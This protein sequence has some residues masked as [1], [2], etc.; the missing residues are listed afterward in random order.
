MVVRSLK[1]KLFVAVV[2]LGVLPFSLSV[3]VEAYLAHRRLIAETRERL[4]TAPLPVLRRMEILLFARWN[5]VHLLSHMPLFQDSEGVGY[6]AAILRRA[7]DL[8]QPDAWLALANERGRILASSDEKFMDTDASE[9]RWFREAGKISFRD[10]REAARS[11]YISE[12]YVPPSGDGRLVMCFNSPLYDTGGR[13]RGVVHSEIKLSA[14]IPFLSSLRMGK[15]GRALLV[16]GDG[17]ILLDDQN[18]LPPIART[19]AGHPAFV[20]VLAGEMPVV[21]DRDL[22]GDAAL[23]SAFPI[24]GFG[25]YPGV[26]WFVLVSQKE[27]EIFAPV[28]SMF[29]IH[30]TVGLL[31]VGFI[32]LGGFFLFDRKI[33]KPVGQLMERVHSLE[34]QGPMPEEDTMNYSEDEIGRLERAFSDMVHSLSIKEKARKELQERLVQKERLAAIGEM[35][36]GVAHQ[37]KNPLATIKVVSQALSEEFSSHA[38]TQ[39]ALS[40]IDKEVNRLNRLLRA[41]FDFAAPGELQKS[42]CDLRAL[43]QEALAQVE[44]KRVEAGVEV[45]EKYAG[46]F[47]LLLL[48]PQQ[49]LQVFINLFHNAVQAMPTGGVLSIDAGVDGEGE[50]AARGVRV[51]V[52]DSGIGISS[53]NLGKI[54]QPFFTTRSSGIGLGL[55]L[56]FKV[57]QKHGGEVRAE[58]QPGRGTTFELF[59]PCGEPL[60]GAGGQTR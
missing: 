48:D 39:V 43:V 8:H 58:S 49:M 40:R 5:D 20:R 33:S 31:G 15:T 29:L 36:A 60:A 17:K 32:F 44:E 30:S 4:A 46:P 7:A 51:R 50:G 47:P 41:F 27:S 6:Q 10:W 25:Q 19:V 53:E 11:M 24:R 52:S 13:F 55:S 23:V 28:R 9:S 35:V 56:V 12:P 26:K 22:D 3:V 21:R 1:A 14:L 57:V 45:K 2:L 59:L 16:R 34:T 18:L 38:S 42:P 54:F 37:I